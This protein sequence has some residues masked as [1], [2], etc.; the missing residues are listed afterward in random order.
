M[1]GRP[2][3][4]MRRISMRFPGNENKRNEDND[5]EAIA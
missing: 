3:K 1:F 4:K 5:L 2:T